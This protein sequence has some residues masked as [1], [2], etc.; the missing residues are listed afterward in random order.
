MTNK[1]IFILTISIIF[2]LCSAK[3][4]NDSSVVNN[5]S[6]NNI[7]LIN[8]NKKIAEIEQ[9]KIDDS[10]KKAE[11]EQQLKTLKTSDNVQKEYLLQR[12]RNL[13]D[14]ET[15]RNSIYKQRIDSL[16][17]TAK[18]YPVLGV[19]KDTL[20]VIYSKIGASKPKDR[21]QNISKRIMKLFDDDF[22]VIDSITV[23]DSDNTVDIIYK[24]SIIMSISE[25]DALWQNKSSHD[26]AKLYSNII[27]NDLKRAKE[28]S[29]LSRIAFRI[30]LLMIVLL[31]IGAMWWLI[32]KGFHKITLYIERNKNKWL[33]NLNYKDYTFL[34]TDQEYKSILFL[35]KPLRWSIYATILYIAI[36][37]N[38]QIKLP[39]FS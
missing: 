39:I 18:G 23:V 13:E 10:I 35:L 30:G 26:L 17:L 25:I 11:L 38:Q 21:A 8:Y 37:C 15:K 9:Q 24:E 29:K 31:L 3:G 22:L 33:K 2:C 6:L 16:K 4:Q 1:R 34:T 36:P 14:L 32:N 5:D 12:I 28:D 19:Y 27:K 7:I 20:F